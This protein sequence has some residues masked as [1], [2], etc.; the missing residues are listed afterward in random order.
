MSDNVRDDERPE[1]APLLLGAGMSRASTGMTLGPAARSAG[2]PRI[3]ESFKGGGL[4]SH[5]ALEDME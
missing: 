2:F 3:P 5:D 1:T 4:L